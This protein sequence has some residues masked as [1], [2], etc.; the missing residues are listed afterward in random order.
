MSCWDFI[1]KL[2]VT[3]GSEGYAMNAAGCR[4]SIRNTLK[5]SQP[6]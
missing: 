2:K 4:V 1:P 3:K 6:T 5:P